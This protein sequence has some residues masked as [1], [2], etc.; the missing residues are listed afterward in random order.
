MT[1]QKKAG[2]GLVGYFV[3]LLVFATVLVPAL[4]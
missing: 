2:A 4:T 1:S 3:I